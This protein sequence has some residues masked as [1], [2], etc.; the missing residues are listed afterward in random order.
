MK[1]QPSKD[2]FAMPQIPESSDVRNDKRHA[3]LILA[4]D[5]PEVDAP[6]FQ[7]EPAATSVIAR[8]HDLVLQRFVGEVVANA[9]RKIEPLSVFAAVTQER[10]DLVRKRLL[11]RCLSGRHGGKITQRRVVIQPKESNRAKKFAVRLRLNQRAN[12]HKSLILRV[13]LENLLEVIRAAGR[14]L[15]ITHDGRPIARPE[16]KRKG[17]NRIQRLKNVPLAVHNGPAKRGIEIMLL[18]DAPGNQLL[19]LLVAGL[20][21]QSLRETVLHFAGVGQRGIAVKADEIGE[22]VHT[23]HVPV[24]DGRL[25]RVLVFSPWLVLFGRR[26]E[27]SLE[28]WWPQL[29]GK[30]ARVTRDC[31]TT[32]KTGRIQRISVA[33]RTKRR[34]TRHSKPRP[35]M[36]WKRDARGKFH[37]R[38]T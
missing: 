26:L 20:R 23:R 33:R 21:I 12:G 32:Y 8:L 38:N 19:R 27:E 24:S 17:R 34:R 3:K 6:V 10:T 4:P 37:S 13:V 14:D 11:K 25:D 16:R 18:C 30:F 35:E 5:L 22:I 31:R 9:P 36:H 2:F 28:R 29:Y 15:E 7:R 1:F